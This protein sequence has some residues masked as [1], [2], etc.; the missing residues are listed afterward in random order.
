MAVE[1]RSRRREP[2]QPGLEVPA[3][4]LHSPLI[5]K[6]T[7]EVRKISESQE[8]SIALLL[9][10]PDVVRGER[11]VRRQQSD[12]EIAAVLPRQEPVNGL[13]AGLLVTL[14]M[15]HLPCDYDGR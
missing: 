6:P 3:N 10:G 9:C 13:S 8:S 14:M 11:R 12:A 1:S 5:L 15:L 7:L 2:I 4:P